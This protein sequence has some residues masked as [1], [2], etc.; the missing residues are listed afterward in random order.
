MRYAAF[1]I[2][3]VFGSVFL[4]MNLSGPVSKSP[5]LWDALPM[6]S[7]PVTLFVASVVGLKFEK[8][9]GWWLLG[10]AGVTAVLLVARGSL[11]SSNVERLAIGIAFLCL[12]MLC[13]GLLWL[14]HSNHRQPNGSRL[15]WMS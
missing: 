15:P 5:T 7:G 10:G 11:V 9:A 13:A 6:L 8:V 2:G 3:A 1:A 4:F 12:P 14:T